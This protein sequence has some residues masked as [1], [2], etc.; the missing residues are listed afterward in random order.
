MPVTVIAT[1]NVKAESADAA[2]DILKRAVVAIHDEPGCALY[3]L[4]EAGGRFI[5]V[6]EWA[7]ED[8]LLVHNA[9]PAVARMVDELSGYLDGQA[10]IVVAEPVVAGNPAKGRLRP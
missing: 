10:D 2:R 4:H 6:E 3:S 5:F 1:L 8:A 7:D 9:G